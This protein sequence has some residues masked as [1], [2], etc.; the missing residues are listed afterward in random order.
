MASRGLT[1]DQLRQRYYAK[2][3]GGPSSSASGRAAPGVRGGEAHVV[4][5]PYGGY[6][7][8]QEQ[9]QMNY[10]IELN[11]VTTKIAEEAAKVPARA[12]KGARAGNRNP[13]AGA[14]ARP[15]SRPGDLPPAFSPWRLAGS[16]RHRAGGG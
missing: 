9:A 13:V 11:E 12:A 8:A 4:D 3:G 1:A 5:N 7:D 16:C 6:Q 15:A 14:L 10:N 2:H